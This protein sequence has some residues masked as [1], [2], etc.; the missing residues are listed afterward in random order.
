MKIIM[1]TILFWGESCKNDKDGKKSAFVFPNRCKSEWGALL[2]QTAVWCVKALLVCREA[3]RHR[4]RMW[5]QRRSL[6]HAHPWFWLMM[7]HLMWQLLSQHLT[8]CCLLQ[9]SRRCLFLHTTHSFMHIHTPTHTRMHTHTH[10]HTHTHVEEH[11]HNTSA[12]RQS[13]SYTLACYNSST[14]VITHTH[15]DTHTQ[16]AQKGTCC[17]RTSCFDQGLPAYL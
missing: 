11:S 16:N 15:T 6:S 5:L 13:L 10:T 4:G 3:E 12:C 8:A 2:W 17:I 1:M 7:R 9:C 14:H